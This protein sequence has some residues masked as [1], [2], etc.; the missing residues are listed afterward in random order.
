MLGH[1]M[2]IFVRKF[3][4]ALLILLGTIVWS[5]TMVKSGLN[6]K[7]GIGFW[8]A[9]GHDGVWHLSV[10]QSLTRQTLEMPVFSGENIKN[11]HL[12]FDVLLAILTK[13]SGISASFWYFQIM[14]P[15]MALGIGVVVYKWVCRWKGELAAWW[16]VFFVYFGGS[17]SWILGKGES[18]F[19]SQQAIST[20]INPPFAL[21]LLIL[22]TILYVLP[23]VKRIRSWAFVTAMVL[24]A[25]LPSIKIYAGILAFA[26]MGVLAIKNKLYRQ[27]T[28]VSSIVAFAFFWPIN[29]NSTG[30]LVFQ[31]GWFLETMVNLS[32]RVYLPRIYYWMKSELISKKILGYGVALVMFILG[33]L[34]TRVIFIFNKHKLDDNYIFA[35]SSMLVGLVFPMFFLQS[36]TPWNT[37]QFLYYFLFFA[38]ILS[39]IAVTEILKNKHRYAIYVLSIIFVLSALPTTWQSLPNYLPNRP[40]AQIPKSELEALNFLKTQ[41]TGVVLTPVFDENAARIAELTPPRPLYLYTSTAYVSAYAD[42]PVYLEDEINLNITGFNWKLR[43]DDVVRLFETDNKIMARNFLLEKNISYIYLPSIADRR[44]KLSPTDLGFKSIFENSK[45]GIWGKN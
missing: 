27:L 38:A 45:V 21:S 3:K 24:L 18:A 43:R 15:L 6:Y 22:S 17:W 32:D 31:P 28:I 39:G 5:V 1:F 30:L 29:K 7:Y 35:Y 10:I 36:G 25:V 4:T 34:G 33:N 2:S 20:L 37:I 42:K 16:A 14:P 44:P 11:Y 23:Q 40:P 19:W 8:G 12:G 13:I 9:N 26:G 41:K